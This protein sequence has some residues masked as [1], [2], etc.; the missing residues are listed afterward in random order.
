MRMPSVSHQPEPHDPP[1][2]QAE[3]RTLQVSA[4]V[5][6]ASVAALYYVQ[7]D[8]PAETELGHL[9]SAPLAAPSHELPPLQTGQAPVEPLAAH[10]SRRQRKQITKTLALVA[11]LIVALGLSALTVFAQTTPPILVQKGTPSAPTTP[12]TVPPSPQPT[13]STHPAA[14]APMPTPQAQIPWVPST[15]PPGWTSAGL[16]MGDAIFAERTALTFTDRE[17]GLDFRNVGTRAQHRGT[18]TASVFILSAGG[19]ARFFQND[20]R[21]INNTLFDQ[22]EAEQR[23]QSAV[24]SV[25]NLTGFVEQGHQPFARVDVSF[26]LWQSRLQQGQ[27]NI[28]FEGDPAT[29]QPR[30][31]HMSVLLVRVTPGTQGA[32][33]PMGGTGWL[34]SSYGLDVS[35]PLAILQ[36]A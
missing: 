34:V 31:H 14:K 6:E 33:A 7:D 2:L 26:F 30:L 9:I 20:L 19:K 1:H 8:E 4:T 32:N 25:P 36:P 15:L 28:G 23:I 11:L 29:G 35:T 17:E 16:T 13:R 18:F 22:V 24:N 5:P 21:A 10:R 3:D 12:T 27:R